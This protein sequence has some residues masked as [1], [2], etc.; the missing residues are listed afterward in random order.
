RLEGPS[1]GRSEF[2]L[3]VPGRYRWLPFE[4]PSAIRIGDRL[5]A[6]GET[7]E[8]ATGNH[9]AEF[10]EDV[11]RGMLVLAVGDPPTT[12]PLAFYKTY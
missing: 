4:T 5:L 6:P 1:G 9:T 8:L 3:I 7:A 10:V 2:E 11:S 12:A